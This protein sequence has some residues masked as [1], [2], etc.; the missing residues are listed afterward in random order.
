ML[1]DFKEKDQDDLESLSD[2]EKD[3]IM[4]GTGYALSVSHSTTA[5]SMDS[6]YRAFNQSRYDW[7]VAASYCPQSSDKPPS[8]LFMAEQVDRAFEALQKKLP[9]ASAIEPAKVNCMV[10][11]ANLNQSGKFPAA[12]WLASNLLVILQKYAEAKIILYTGTDNFEALYFNSEKANLTS[13]LLA[14]GSKRDLDPILSKIQYYPKTTV[15]REVT[16][17]VKTRPKPGMMSPTHTLSPWGS[18]TAGSL[19]ASPVASPGSADNK[20]A[21]GGA[22]GSA[23]SAITDV[24]EQR[25]T[26][27]ESAASSSAIA[28][29]VVSA[30]TTPPQHAKAYAK[31]PTSPLRDVLDPYTA[32]L[33][34]N[35]HY[36][37]PADGVVHKQQPCLVFAAQ[38]AAKAEEQKPEAEAV[39]PAG[40]R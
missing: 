10:L 2:S 28:N 21:N 19:V 6:Y 17:E 7:I 29:T 13:K 36:A 26:S 31:P 8:D 38:P 24:A 12:G 34:V 30:P 16:K 25:V 15:L 39:A 14:L 35:T 27:P 33:T 4:Q 11:E 9:G 18:L 32:S 5:E 22:G 37:E 40:S 23:V 1:G 20:V 3:F